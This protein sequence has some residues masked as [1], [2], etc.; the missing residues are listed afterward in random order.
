VVCEDKVDIFRKLASEHALRFIDDVLRYFEDLRRNGARE[1]L[2]LLL[3]GSL[4]GNEDLVGTFSGDN[5]STLA[6]IA[7]AL[8]Q[9]DELMTL[10]ILD[11]D[12]AGIEDFP[13]CIYGSS[14]LLG[15]GLVRPQPAG[16]SKA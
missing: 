10:V 16:K 5:F 13:D 1:F 14:P 8:A 11:E 4:D 12:D 3:A 7:Y 2:H 15:C 9:K 6:S